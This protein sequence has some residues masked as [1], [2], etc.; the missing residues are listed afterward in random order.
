MPPGACSFVRIERRLNHYAVQAVP[1]RQVLSFLDSS[2]Y[3]KGLTTSMERH[4]ITAK[5][6]TRLSATEG[7]DRLSTTHR[8]S[9]LRSTR[10]ATTSSSL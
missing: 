5:P 1:R 9:H 10:Q 8:Y 6:A 7:L 3:H 4:K 2:L